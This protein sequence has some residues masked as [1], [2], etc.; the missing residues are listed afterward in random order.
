MLEKKIINFG[1]ERFECQKIWIAKFVSVSDDQF[2][3][4]VS[5][6]D[7]YRL[8][9]SFVRP[10][11]MTLLSVLA[12]LWSFHSVPPFALPNLGKNRKTVFFCFIF[13]FR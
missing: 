3:Y 11:D 9:R 13:G 5:L 4:F 8:F 1:I 2:I 10:S 12:L 7:L 6:S